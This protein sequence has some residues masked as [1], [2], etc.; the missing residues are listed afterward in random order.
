MCYYC[1][2]TSASGQFTH[3]AGREGFSI[4]DFSV[5]A[6]SILEIPQSR[7]ES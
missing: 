5:S 1:H 7:G 4:Y 2:I 3:C 6:I